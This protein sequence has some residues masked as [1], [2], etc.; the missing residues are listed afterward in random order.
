MSSS[1]RVNPCYPSIDGAS[2]WPTDFG[3][4]ATRF[5]L[6]GRDQSCFLAS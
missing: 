1:A 2:V 5:N 6:R 4:D 3:P